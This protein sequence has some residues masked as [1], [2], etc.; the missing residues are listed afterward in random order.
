MVFDEYMVFYII[1]M[2]G[3]SIFLIQWILFKLWHIW[4][5]SKFTILL[6]HQ[7][8]TKIWPVPWWGYNMAILRGQFFELKF[9]RK[10]TVFWHKNILCVQ[11]IKIYTFE[12]KSVFEF[13]AQN[14]SLVAKS[15]V[16]YRVHSRQVNMR[17]QNISVG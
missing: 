9:T 14:V 5:E 3:V 10:Y 7:S 13:S 8:D 6:W 1:F 16:R 17:L 11:N 15:T 2:F 12:P 4:A